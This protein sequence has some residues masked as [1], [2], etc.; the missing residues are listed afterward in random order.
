MIAV[1]SAVPDNPATARRTILRYWF[2][3][4]LSGWA[5]WRKNGRVMAPA[6]ERHEHHRVQRNNHGNHCRQ[7]DDVH[8]AFL[9]VIEAPRA[10]GNM[11]H[12]CGSQEM[13]LAT[14]HRF[15]LATLMTKW[16]ERRRHGLCVDFSLRSDRE[17]RG[18]RDAI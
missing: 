15:H 18:V 16:R 11:R 8:R 3:H 5:V 12:R 7:R 17:K 4:R 9:Q 2:R 13:T 14:V 10:T 6:V 1:Y